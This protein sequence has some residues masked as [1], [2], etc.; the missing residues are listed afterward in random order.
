MNINKVLE[1]LSNGHH[2]SNIQMQEVIK[3]CMTG[4]LSDV[5]TAAFL[6][7]MRMKGETVEELTAAATI[8]TEYA[9]PIHLGSGLVDIVGTGGDGKN[10]FN[11][12]TISSFVVAAAGLPIA[13]HG[14]HS[15]SSR[16][17]SADFLL[18]AG[19][20]LELSDQALADCIEQ[21]QIAF[22][23]G[24]HFHPA[25]RHVRR[26]RQQLGIR[27][28]FNLLG[29]LLNPAGVK[30][31]V[32]GV[33]DKQWL[34]PVAQ[35]L[36]HIGSERAL[37]VSSD[38]GLDEI[39]IAAC[40]HVMEYHNSELKSWVIDPKRYHCYHPNLDA[41]IVENPAESLII[42]E[43][44]FSGASGPA[45]DIVVL[46]AAAVLYCGGL[47]LDFESAI[48]KARLAIDSGLAKHRFNQLRELTQTCKP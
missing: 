19:F 1:Q 48:E 46:N 11:I 8:M 39:S 2:L 10:T 36:A 30:R 6:A 37:V 27:T 41:I 22:L 29:P 34:K 3:N 20:E 26:A 31:Q 17:G 18:Q 12:S 9:R 13:K 7:L 24:P 4:D 35:V 45:R 43:A 23:F 25:M 33:F 44:V 16:S 5:Q 40:T 28:L 21:C 32:V 14:S 42:A 47:C 15:V 38:D